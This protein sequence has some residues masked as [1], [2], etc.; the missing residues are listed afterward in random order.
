MEVEIPLA[1]VD[2]AHGAG[3]PV[4]LLEW[5]VPKWLPIDTAIKRIPRL[6]NYLGLGDSMLEL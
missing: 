3:K 1:L 4:A 5:Y 6:G 2:Y